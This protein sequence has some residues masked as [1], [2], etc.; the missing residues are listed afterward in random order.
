MGAT[1]PIFQEGG[2]LSTSPA[3]FGALS[4]CGRGRKWEWRDAVGRTDEGGEEGHR[5]SPPP[6][7]SPA[8]TEEEE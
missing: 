1:P 6:L 7:L 5:R 2:G 3:S 8:A 4:V